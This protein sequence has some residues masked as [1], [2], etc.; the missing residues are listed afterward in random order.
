MYVRP[1]ITIVKSYCTKCN[2]ESTHSVLPIERIVGAKYYQY[3]N[4][5]KKFVEFKIN[6]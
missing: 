5:C 2:N 3:C 1:S 4:K 6:I